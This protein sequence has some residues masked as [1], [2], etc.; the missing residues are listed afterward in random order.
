MAQLAQR[1]TLKLLRKTEV[2]GGRNLQDKAL[3]SMRSVA[4]MGSW[5]RRLGNVHGEIMNFRG[6]PKLPATCYVN[7][8]VNIPKPEARRRF[9]RTRP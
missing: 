6:Q 4:Q 9:R 2:A 8:A 1:D 3:E 7:I 5:G